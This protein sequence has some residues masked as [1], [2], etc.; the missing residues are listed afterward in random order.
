VTF[1]LVVCA[2]L[3]TKQAACHQEGRDCVAGGEIVCL[4]FHH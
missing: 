1:S 2:P 4:S 3:L